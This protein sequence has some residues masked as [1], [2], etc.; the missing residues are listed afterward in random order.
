[1]YPTSDQRAKKA[2]SIRNHQSRSSLRVPVDFSAADS[3]LPPGGSASFPQTGTVL[4]TGPLP[5]TSFSANR[6]PAVCTDR[7]GKRYGNFNALIDLTLT[8]P[9]GEVFGLLGPNGAGKTTLIRTLLGF[10]HRTSGEAQVMGIDP[11]GDSVAVRRQVS[12]LPGDA[13]LPRQMRGRGVLRFF[14]DIQPEGDLE[15]S[16]AVADRLELDLRRHVGFMSTGMRQKLAIAAVLGSRAPLLILDEPTANLDPTVRSRVLEMVMD[17]KQAGRTVIFSS[18]VLSEIEEVCD[19]V[20]LLRRGRLAHQQ[21]LT[22]LK[23]RHRIVARRKSD[24]R[25]IEIP[26]DLVTAVASVKQVDD[27][28][29]IETMGDLA[30]ALPWLTTLGLRELRVE[31][32]GLRAVYDA[33]HFDE[34]PAL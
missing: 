11:V 28:V 26:P 18:H 21:C 12:Y 3:P 1:V 31:A 32:F 33:V 4:K 34:V 13:R 16:L 20:A 24:S 9:Q 7:L 19:R 23:A 6:C 5:Q 2:L 8:V 17:A 30:P 27:R 29:T 22:D 15:H 25:P 10:L 14:A